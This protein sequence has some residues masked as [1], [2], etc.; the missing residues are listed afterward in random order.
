MPRETLDEQL[1]SLQK[2][3]LAMGDLVDRAIERSI[4]ALANRDLALAEKIIQ[5]DETINRAQRDL[6]EKCLVLLA[7]QQPLA[8]DLRAIIAVSNIATELERIGDYAKG[9]AKI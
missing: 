3:L 4:Q 8:S 5:E 2:D 9:I 7:T 1:N 6:D